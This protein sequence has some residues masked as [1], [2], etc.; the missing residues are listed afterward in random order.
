MA[1]ANL[2]VTD[3]TVSCGITIICHYTQLGF[4][5][6]QEFCLDLAIVCNLQ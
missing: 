6:S 1:Y 5:P 3:F 2:K 4:L